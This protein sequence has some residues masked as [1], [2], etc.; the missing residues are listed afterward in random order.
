MKYFLSLM[1]AVCCLSLWSD[2]KSNSSSSDNP[3]RGR[4]RGWRSGRRGGGFMEQI[5]KK[6]PGEYAEIEKL[7]ENDP[8]KARSKMRELMRKTM[9]EMGMMRRGGHGGFP[10]LSEEQIK[11]L[12]TKFPAEFAEYEKLKESDSAKAKEKLRGM[13]KKYFEENALANDKF[14]RDRNRRATAHILA[15]L[16]SRYPEKMQ[17]IEKLQKTDPDAARKELRNLFA[18]AELTVPSGQKELNYEYIPPQQ[19]NF[20]NGMMPRGNFP[21]GGR[22]MGPWGGRR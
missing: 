15:E 6:Y 11:E 14:L 9:P 8:E 17:E 16:K 7:R 21:F 1:L 12:K 22:M 10:E 4:S 13:M 2:E 19:Q 20:R 5:K 18:E 3:E